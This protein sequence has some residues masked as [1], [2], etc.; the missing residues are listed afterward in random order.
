MCTK[1]PECVEAV[2]FGVVGFKIDRFLLREDTPI[3]VLRLRNR[4]SKVATAESAADWTLEQ[5]S[6]EYAQKDVALALF[7]SIPQIEHSKYF[8]SQLVAQA[9]RQAGVELL[10]GRTSAKISPGALAESPELEDVTSSCKRIATPVERLRWTAFLEDD[11]TVTPHIV[12]VGLRQ[13]ILNELRPT[14][15]DAG[16]NAETYAALLQ[17]MAEGWKDG[18]PWITRVDKELSK[19]IVDSG[20]FGLIETFL[21][22]DSDH[23]F[24]D[25]HL[26]QM[27]EAGRLPREQ[28]PE[29]QQHFEYLLAKRD[30]TLAEL[31]DQNRVPWW[32]Y[33]KTGLITFKLE[34]AI[35]QTTISLLSRQRDSIA[36][37]V[38]LLRKLQQAMGN[39]A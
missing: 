36:K 32:G 28:F 23:F 34:L 12:E 11:S 17:A 13:K 31:K 10:P 24:I 16:V 25:T 33:A 8:C 19:L 6:R 20:L 26:F 39:R 4:E 14:L 27:I 29:L 38:D 7:R 2:G 15:Q 1:P 30:R 5:V 22:S 37:C 35:S 9:Y 18:Q 21:P 3:K